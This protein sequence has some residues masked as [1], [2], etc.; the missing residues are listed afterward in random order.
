M[1]SGS[2]TKAGYQRSAEGMNIEEAAR[3]LQSLIR[4]ACLT[5]YRN[6]NPTHVT[7]DYNEGEIILGDS[8]VVLSFD[9]TNELGQPWGVAPLHFDPGGWDARMG[10]GEDPSLEAGEWVSFSTAA[11]ACRAAVLLLVTLRMDDW[12]AGMAEEGAEK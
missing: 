8:E 10:D 9:A 12:L 4:N 7:P 1:S 2:G 5:D 3:L 6:T 11:E